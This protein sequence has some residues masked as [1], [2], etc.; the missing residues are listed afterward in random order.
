MLGPAR[1]AGKQVVYTRVAFSP[2]HNYLVPNSRPLMGGGMTPRTPNGV[3]VPA[4][5][6]LGR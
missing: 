6:D 1:H 5:D 4:T 3:S 2:D